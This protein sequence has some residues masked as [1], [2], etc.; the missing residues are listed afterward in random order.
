MLVFRFS[1]RRRGRASALQAEGGVQTNRDDVAF[2]VVAAQLCFLVVLMVFGSD[3]MAPSLG[4]PTD[5]A[6]LGP[7]LQHPAML[8]HPPVVFLGY[9]C[10]AF[11]LALAIAALLT[12]QVDSGCARDMRPW[13]LAGWTALGAGILLGADWAYEE[14][15][16]GGYWSWD[17]VEN[18]SLIPWLTGTALVHAS[19]TWQRQGGLKKS[20]LLLAVATLG[21]CNFAAF[22]TRSGIFSS[23]HAFSHS[24]IGWMFLGLI[25]AIATAGAI[26]VL[27][28]RKSLVA[29]R[30]IGSIWARQ[31]LVAISCTALVILA[32]VALLGTVATPLSDILF[33]RKIVFGPEFFNAAFIPI[34]LLLLAAMA[35]F[36]FLRWNGAPSMQQRTMLA[37]ALGAGAATALVAFALGVRHPIALSVAGLTGLAVVGTVATIA[38]DV[39]RRTFAAFII[40]AGITCLAIGVT[41]SS[42]GTIQ[43]EANLKE[44]ETM[45]W[46]G[47]SIRFARLDQ[48]ELPDRTVL[49]TQLEISTSNHAVAVLLP[50]QQYHRSHGQWTTEVAIHSTWAED[51]YVV[52]HGGKARSKAHFTFVVNPMMRWLWFGGAIAG[53][54]AIGGF[55]PVGRRRREQ[56]NGGHQ[57]SQSLGGPEIISTRRDRCAA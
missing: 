11:P 51:F 18:G 30:P 48:R 14:L 40:H 52:V 50:S 47:R 22:V 53:I 41:G 16:W 36:P 37:V 44:G 28:K 24:P 8:L 1:R 55:L 5:G 27:V 15:G 21:L 35:V 43:T 19:M 49:E 20:S 57:D 42:L 56:H 7:L 38:I 17:P 13:S 33:G 45:E 3:P 32:L 34:G 23:V 10:Y 26:L 31:S 2:G 4:N 39:R 54:G 29:D 25:A 12:G 9:A 6:G 46:G